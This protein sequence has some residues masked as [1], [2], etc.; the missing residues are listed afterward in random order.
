MHKEIIEIEP[1]L[2]WS[3]SF[4]SVLM[5]ENFP[6]DSFYQCIKERIDIYV[7]SIHWALGFVSVSMREKLVFTS[8]SRTK[9]PRLVYL[10][11][12]VRE[13]PHFSFYQCFMRE[14]HIL[15]YSFTSAL[16]GK[17]SL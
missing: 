7:D 17:N 4:V 5:E 11:I 2:R 1:P 9:I 12:K 13:I 10:C 3:V 8:E 15:G 14:I 16:R 6:K